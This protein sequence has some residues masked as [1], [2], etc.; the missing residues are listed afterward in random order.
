MT[1]GEHRSVVAGEPP[2]SEEWRLV[3]YEDV[4]VEDEQPG[5]TIT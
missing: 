3:F 5:R 1:A 4:E 2:D